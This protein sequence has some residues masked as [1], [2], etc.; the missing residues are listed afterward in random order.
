MRIGTKSFLRLSNKPGW[1]FSPSKV[2]SPPLSRLWS[3]LLLTKH[4][5]FLHCAPNSF[6]ESYDFIHVMIYCWLSALQIPWRIAWN[7]SIFYFL[8]FS[9]V[10]LRPQ[11]TNYRYQ[12]RTLGAVVLKWGCG[13][14]VQGENI[15][16]RITSTNS[17]E[18]FIQKCTKTDLEPWSLEECGGARHPRSSSLIAA[19]TNTSSTTS[20]QKNLYRT[21]GTLPSRPPDLGR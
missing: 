15:A 9:L 18:S 12:F 19:K 14:G 8:W 3:R 5:P 17:K 20:K 10:K 21:D 11:V 1:S 13:C 4:F 6:G 7:T 2:S 16:V